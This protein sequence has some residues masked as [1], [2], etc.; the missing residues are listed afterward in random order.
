MATVSLSITTPSG[1]EVVNTT[2]K[3]VDL[4]RIITAHRAMRYGPIDVGTLEV[5]EIRDRTD[6]EIIREIFS[7]FL[8]EAIAV[9]EAYEKKQ[10]A[11]LIV[12]LDR[13]TL[14]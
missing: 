14:S 1:T 6:K 4:K 7:S 3:N 2:V 13:P 9:V 11:A 5:P 10:A 8:Q 12:P